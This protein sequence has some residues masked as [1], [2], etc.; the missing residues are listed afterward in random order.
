MSSFT[1]ITM[2]K[3]N[4]KLKQSNNKQGLSTFTNLFSNLERLEESS[5]DWSVNTPVQASSNTCVQPQSILMSNPCN[6]NVF[7]LSG[8]G[9]TILNYSN[10]QLLD[11][12]S[13]DRA[14]Q[15]LS[16]FGR[17]ESLSENI[18]NIVC[19]LKRIRKHIKHHL[20]FAVVA[21][22]LWDLISMIY[23]SK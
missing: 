19:S 7:V 16:L 14:C 10:D 6:I 3:S 13:W 18:T 8:L 20:E 2:S 17:K 22:N 4:M 9:S 5:M 21:K 11:P 12:N 15:A 23:Q 1:F